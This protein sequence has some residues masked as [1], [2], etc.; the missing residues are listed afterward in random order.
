MKTEKLIFR[1]V[2][3]I[4][5]LFL[6]ANSDAQ[7]SQKLVT[8]TKTIKK[9]FDKDTIKHLYITNSLGD[10]SISGWNKN[11]LEMIITV[12]VIG[13]ADGDVNTFIDNLTPNPEYTGNK[14]EGFGV[15]SV[16]DF[17]HIK[18]YCCPD[19]KKVYK[20]WFEK[21]VSVKEFSINYEIK[22][23]KSLDYINLNNAY[24]NI[25]LPSFTGRLS[26]NLRNGNLK[27]GNLNIVDSD[28]ECA[29]ISVR[30]GKVN[31]GK[32]TNAK[33]DFYSCDLVKINALS[34]SKLNTSFSNIRLGFASGINLQS[35]SDDYLITTLDSVVGRGQFTT[36]VI[37]NLE[38]YLMFDNRSGEID[39]KN[40]NPDFNSIFLDGQFNQYTL[41]VANLNYLLSANLETT[42][43]NCNDTICSKSF[44]N[45]AMN[46]NLTI[47]KKVGIPSNFSKITLNCSKCNIDL[48]DD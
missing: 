37:E 13:W 45:Q 25:S 48:L 30:H 44:K 1:C 3:L 39:I 4:V 24:G 5:S 38:S 7:E 42:E 27:I 10:I 14:E 20:R 22:I 41:Q 32:V 31:I 34:N 18:N 46:S 29:T 8:K 2:L 36:M 35:K 47:N 6:F 28:Y 17:K 43:I 9:I 23:P 21:N 33:L 40:I 19:A 26:I 11:Y 15:W 16:Y 12:E